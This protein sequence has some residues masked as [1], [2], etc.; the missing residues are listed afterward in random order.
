M[1]TK[2]QKSKNKRLIKAIINYITNNARLY[3]KYLAPKRTRKC[4]LEK[5]LE[6]IIQLMSLG[7]PWRRADE[8]KFSG[9][10]A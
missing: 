9:K 7:L 1:L 4:S 10:L 6:V 3:D 8:F 5:Q 2:K